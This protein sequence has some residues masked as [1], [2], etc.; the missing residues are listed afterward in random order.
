MLKKII[1]SSAMLGC[2]LLINAQDAQTKKKVVIINKTNIDGKVTET[3][4][5]AEGE[6]ADKLLKEM[7]ANE[8]ENIN[9]NT[10]NGQQVIS[11]NKS[12]NKMITTDDKGTKVKIIKIDGDNVNEMEWEGDG[13]MPEEIAKEMQNVKIK[14][15]KDGDNMTITIDA[16]GDEDNGKVIVMEEGGKGKK[17]KNMMIIEEN[18]KVF[19]DTKGRKLRMEKGNENK[20]TLGVAID[21][22]DDG[23]VI[24]DVVTGS[25]AAKAG[26]RRDDVLL[27][28]N[29]KYIFTSDGLLKALRP[30]N[31][32]DKV[33]VR[34]IR[35]GKEKSANAVLSGRN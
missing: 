31:P 18:D 15:I 5:E 1:I 25:A 35:D 24:T 33:K 10:D 28:V 27:K 13:D 26:L 21:D 20:A 17:K 29:D 34:Y 6:E 9:I 7:D 30:F 23:V 12:T 14:K 22:T 11:I 16:E 32:G 19:F 2:S 3:R 8:I 4:K